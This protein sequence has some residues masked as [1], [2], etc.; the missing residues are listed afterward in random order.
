[1]FDAR[2]HRFVR[3]EYDYGT[4]VGARK[5]PRQVRETYAEGV[6]HMRFEFFHNR[7]ATGEWR[8]VKSFSNG[9][10]C[11][12]RVTLDLDWPGETAMRTRLQ[13]WI[14][15]PSGPW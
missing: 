1:M 13:R 5:S 2:R 6:S 3:R 12:V 10:P 14:V 8:G 15:F 4:A 9:L 11:L 7:R